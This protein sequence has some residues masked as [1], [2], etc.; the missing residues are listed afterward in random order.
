MEHF[1]QNIQ[2][3]ANCTGY[4]HKMARELPDYCKVV[5]VGV[6]KGQSLFYLA[7]ELHNQGKH[8]ELYAVDTW[9]GSKEHAERIKKE[10]SPE[11][12]FDFFLNKWESEFVK[13]IKVKKTSLQAA[14]D[15][16][17]AGM[18]F[19]Q[20]FIDAN[21]TYEAVKQD[22]MVWVLCLNSTGIMAGDDYHSS[23]PGVMKAVQEVIP[24]DRLKVEGVIWY[25]AA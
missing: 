7:V 1:Y 9:E 6:W 23:W 8:C 22:I 16:K 25:R 21:H 15:F 3:W 20:V 17:N 14:E 12:V 10:G 13:I 2:G 18:T 4:Y 19:H 24:A 5:E 11:D